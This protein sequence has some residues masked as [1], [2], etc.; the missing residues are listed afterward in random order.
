MI[1]GFNWL[2]VVLNLSKFIVSGLEVAVKKTPI[3][4]VAVNVNPDNPAQLIAS[5]EEGWRV[6]EWQWQRSTD[7]KTWIDVTGDGAAYNRTNDDDGKQLRVIA[8]VKYATTDDEVGKAVSEPVQVGVGMILGID[9]KVD[10]TGKVDIPLL[11][12]LSCEEGVQI[13]DVKYT[14]QKQ[15]NGS[16]SKEAVTSTNATNDTSTYT[17]SLDDGGATIWVVAEYKDAQ[18]TVQSVLK[19]TVIDSVKTDA[20]ICS[21]GAR[22]SITSAMKVGDE[23]FAKEGTGGAAARFTYSWCLEGATEPLQTESKSSYVVSPQCAGKNLYVAIQYKDDSGATYPNPPA[24]SAPIA[25]PAPSVTITPAAPKVNTELT[26]NVS[27]VNVKA[28]G[29]GNGFSVQYQW[30]FKKD[31]SS[32]FISSREPQETKTYKPKEAGQYKVKIT[33][34]DNANGEA[35][36]GDPIESAPITVTA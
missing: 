23:L 24:K 5:M 17:P 6:K 35:Q 33:F 18:G 32:E 2:R 16:A 4:D 29:T 30:F 26:A 34:H 19:S 13:S 36:V 8:T 21:D 25:I 9:G 7:G 12:S 10:S 27:N 20:T 28:S 15:K 14:W 31:Q 22:T 1:E 11:A 3:G